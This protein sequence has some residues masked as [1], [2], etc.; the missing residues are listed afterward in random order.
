[1]YKSDQIHSYIY[2]KI[3]LNYYMNGQDKCIQTKN[4]QTNLFPWQN[5]IIKVSWNLTF[6]KKSSK[7]TNDAHG[8]RK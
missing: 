1:V 6:F 4:T 7:C 8:A 3:V 2:D 5:K